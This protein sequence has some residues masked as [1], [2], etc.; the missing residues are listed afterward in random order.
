MVPFDHV[1]GLPVL[2]SLAL[3]QGEPWDSG[4][5]AA[6]IIREAGF[7]V[8]AAGG[9]VRDV[10]L[11]LPVHDIDLATSAHPEHI[12][13][14][15]QDQ[16]WHTIAVGKAFGVIVVVTPSDL[17]IEVATFRNDGAYIDGRRPQSISFSHVSDDVQRRDFTIN[18]LLYDIKNNVVMDYVNGRADLLAGIIRA[19]GDPLARLR[20]DRLRVL[21]ALRFA[22]RLNFCIEP[23]T[24]EAVKATSLVGLS[25]ERIMQEWSKALAGSGRS[26]WLQL[27]SESGH[28]VNICAPL[29][30]CSSTDISTLGRRLDEIQ[31]NDPRSLSLAL[32]LSPLWLSP[33]SQASAESWLDDQRLPSAVVRAARWMLDHAAAWSRLSSLPL[34]ARRRLWRHVDGPL[35]GRLIELLHGDQPLRKE[36]VQTLSAEMKSE[37]GVSWSSPLRAEELIAMGLLP[38]PQLGALLREIENADLEGRFMNH[39]AAETFARARIAELKNREAK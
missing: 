13:K 28:L 19:V 9:C 25:G 32:W 15:F 38:G 23:E 1:S 24:W 14:I 33:A 37:Q 8:Y 2:W 12:E 34:A 3:P 30:A 31:S 39:A 11:G 35:L 18:A 5:K 29:A 20:E 6:K 22:A 7:Q 36:A 16:N 21:R 4:I 26:R 27:L 10:L 17:N